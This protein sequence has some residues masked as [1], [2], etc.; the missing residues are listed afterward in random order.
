MIHLYRHNVIACFARDLRS[1]S[2]SAGG[3][4]NDGQMDSNGSFPAFSGSM[5]RRVRGADTGSMSMSEDG[6]H[7]CSLCGGRGE[8]VTTSLSQ[9]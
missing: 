2:W 5:S 7:T 3:C 4:G 1:T 9:T 6:L 8:S